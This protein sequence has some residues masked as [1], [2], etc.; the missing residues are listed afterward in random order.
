MS[1]T[2]W[3]ADSQSPQWRQMVSTLVVLQV[4][5]GHRHPGSTSPSRPELLSTP[6][7]EDRRLIR[8]AMLSRHALW[9]FSTSSWLW[10]KW[11]KTLG[12]LGKWRSDW[13]WMKKRGRP[14]RLALLDGGSSDF[15]PPRV[16]TAGGLA[17]TLRPPFAVVAAAAAAWPLVPLQQRD[18]S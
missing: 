14:Q 5:A 9:S 6:S 3:I 18:E 10:K 8:W 7:K 2:E 17:S 1:F 11:L 16:L 12:K 4:L 13:D 15:W